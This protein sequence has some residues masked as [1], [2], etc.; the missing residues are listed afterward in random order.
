MNWYL[1]KSYLRYRLKTKYRPKNSSF[2][3][4]V[5]D[6]VVWETYPYY[7]FTAISKIRTALLR[8]KQK[9]E[10]TDLGAGSKKFKNNKR[11]V[12]HLVKYN[13]SSKKQGEL[14]FRMVAYFKPKTIIELGTS[15]GLGTLYLAMGNPSTRVHTIEGCP[16]I[17]KIAERN[18]KAEGI[19]NVTQHVGSFK[20]ELPKLI[21]VLPALDMVYF[22]GH[23]DYMATLMY[24]NMCLPKASES[25]LFIFDDIYWSAGMTKAWNQIIGHPSVAASFDFFDFGIVILKKDMEKIH[26]VVKWS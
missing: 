9:F 23:H 13:A 19:G 8:S 11:S 14:L 2:I 21:H 3:S 6:R 15:L 17:A 18:F 22:D 20:N 5:F 4:D 25:A 26:G 1:I 24:F 12:R 16:E 10:I 7:N